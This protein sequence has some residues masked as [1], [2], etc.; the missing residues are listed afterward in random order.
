MGQA[1]FGR[2][3]RVRGAAR[4]VLA[5]LCA[6]LLAFAILQIPN[7]ERSILGEPD[8]EML[9]TAFK[10]REGIVRGKA[11]P[12]VWLDLDFETL[13]G[14]LARQDGSR[15]LEAGP[16]DRP[17]AAGPAPA[18]PRQT[19]ADLLN[20]TRRSSSSGAGPTAVLLDV[21]L[22]WGGDAAG[23]AAL[24]QALEAW[25]GDPKAPLLMLA[26]EALDTPDGTILPPTPFDRLEADSPSLMF[27]GVGYLADGDGLVRELTTGQ[28]VTRPG[29]PVSAVPLPHAIVAATAAQRAA[30]E[31]IG[32][33]PL[34]RAAWV[35][36][37]VRLRMTALLPP[38]TPGTPGPALSGG[39]VNW[40]LGFQRPNKPKAA[41]VHP[42]WPHR[43]TCGLSHPPLALARV[44]AGDALAAPEAAQS[45]L[46]C[47]ALVIIGADNALLSDRSSTPYGS[48]PGPVVLANGMRGWFDTGPIERGGWQVGRLA[49]QLALLAATVAAVAWAFDAVSDWRRGRISAP[50]SRLG[51]VAGLS[52]GAG[53]L[54]THPLVFKF[55]LAVV[56]FGVGAAVTAVGLDHG[57]WGVLSAPA[58]CAALTEAWQ[59][60]NQDRRAIGSPDQQALR[61][62][63]QPEGSES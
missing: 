18:V 44:A 9:E 58:Y 47:R 19:L 17:L 30:R 35:E 3:G 1:W 62:A 5:P 52:V 31:R 40:H 13:D 4:H 28:C 24:A 22:A 20:W 39:L 51:S 7:A 55:V 29:D 63:V 27:V 61:Q 37:D 36:H 32:D 15:F 46:L 21:D 23:Q 38:C 54:I 45:G 34:E 59:Q 12:V 57:F 25:A 43:A 53:L 56:T 48:L 50:R 33:T 42:S 11:D 41:P 16:I 60:I 10:L 49:L 26:R 6:G 2:D 8:R 14:S